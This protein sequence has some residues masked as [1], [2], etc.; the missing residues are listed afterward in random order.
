MNTILE[1][2]AA[3]MVVLVA[4]VA[5]D[6][7]LHRRRLRRRQRGLTDREVA[8]SQAPYADISVW[9]A[10]APQNGNPYEDT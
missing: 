6:E 4:L 1:I 5:L 3:I 7:L 10:R 2:A 9:P 8:H